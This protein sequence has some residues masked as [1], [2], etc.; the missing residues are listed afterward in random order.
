[1]VVIPQ[2]NS[3]VRSLL[4]SE[5]CEPKVSLGRIQSSMAQGAGY[6]Q[7]ININD[8]HNALRQHNSD[9]APDYGGR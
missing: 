4:V 1:M 2:E 8:G 6:G 9:G 5:Q 7:R 3:L